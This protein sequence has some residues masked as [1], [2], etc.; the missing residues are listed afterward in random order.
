M[1]QNE[2][3]PRLRGPARTARLVPLGYLLAVGAMLG[4]TTNLAKYGADHGLH[5]VTLLVWSTV[6]AAAVLTGATWRGRGRP[7]CS[8]RIA[9]YF[10]LAA[11]LGVAGP[12]L[13]LF[14]AVSRVGAGFVTLALAFPP[15]LTT[16]GALLLRLE[17]FDPWRFLGVV[18]ALSG[19]T[20][21]AYLK[22]Q[23]PDAQA[24]WIG[25]TMLAPVILAAGNLYRTARWPAGASPA[26]LVPGV[27]LAA[28]VLLVAGAGVAGVPLGLDW[29]HPR[30]LLLVAFQTGLS[31]VQYL[32]YFRLQ[33]QGGPVMMSLLGS[34]AAV[35]GVP[36]AVWLLGEEPPAGL[37][38]GAALIAAGIIL[39][40]RPRMAGKQLSRGSGDLNPG[41][42]RGGPVLVVLEGK[43]D[44]G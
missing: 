4:L 15:L 14:G 44:A 12:N 29:S 39:V 19:A 5:P 40:V 41:P 9:E 30:D 25:A 13:L 28:S 43:E 26:S 23:R 20:Y 42:G 17:K 16:V 8:G 33:K 36:V 11:I 3:G 35:V 7:R 34:V 18:V 10:V 24:W 27:L 21:L 37:A 38:V 2:Q 31:S 22:Y 32:L 1:N 6:G